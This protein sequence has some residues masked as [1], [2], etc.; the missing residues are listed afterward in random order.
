LE[1][2]PSLSVLKG[3]CPTPLDSIIK[4]IRKPE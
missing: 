2:P 3:V 4:T 1:G